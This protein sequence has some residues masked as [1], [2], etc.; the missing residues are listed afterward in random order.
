M[1]DRVLHCNSVLFLYRI[2]ATRKLLLYMQR[3]LN[4]ACVQTYMHS[5]KIRAR[6]LALD[7]IA[8]VHRECIVFVYANCVVCVVCEQYS[9]QFAN[10]PAY[11][12]ECDVIRDRGERSPRRRTVQRPVAVCTCATT[13]GVGLIGSPLEIFDSR[14]RM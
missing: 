9:N 7:V 1:P 2:I 6:R 13:L 10:L 14:A 12:F 5:A 11:C 4:A 3:A 8:H